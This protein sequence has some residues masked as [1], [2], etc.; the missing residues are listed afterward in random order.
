MASLVTNKGGRPHYVA[1]LPKDQSLQFRDNFYQAC[2]TF[3]YRDIVAL[4][5]ALGTSPRAVISWKYRERMPRIST[6][7]SV[8]EWTKQG[9]P[10]QL[11]SPGQKASAFSMF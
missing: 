8:L 4:S 7:L 2:S 11:E 6:A 3:K 9:K 5:R 1:R 10:M